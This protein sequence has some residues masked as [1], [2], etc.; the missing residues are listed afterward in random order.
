MLDSDVVVLFWSPATRSSQWVER[1]I[2]FARVRG[3]GA[4][5]IVPVV[6]KPAHAP[7]WLPTLAITVTDVY[8]FS[9]FRHR[10]FSVEM[11]CLL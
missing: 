2:R 4:V 10:H 9:R 3:K 5:E 1:E 11:S 7:T 6:L 8:H